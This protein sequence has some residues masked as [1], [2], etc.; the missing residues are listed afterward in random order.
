M[1]RPPAIPP[2]ANTVN[3]CDNMPLETQKIPGRPHG[4]ANGGPV[5]N[6]LD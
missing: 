6:S 2:A 3:L 5:A 4:N 1:L